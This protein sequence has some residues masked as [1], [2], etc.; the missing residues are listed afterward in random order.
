MK[1]E[2]KISNPSMYNYTRF[3][4]ELMHNLYVSGAPCSTEQPATQSVGTT[5]D[6]TKLACA[7]MTLTTGISS[8][9]SHTHILL[10]GGWIVY[11]NVLYIYFM[12]MVV[13][14]YVANKD[15]LTLYGALYYIFIVLAIMEGTVGMITINSIAWSTTIEYYFVPSTSTYLTYWQKKFS[16]AF[17][18]SKFLSLWNSFVWVRHHH[19]RFTSRNIAFLS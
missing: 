18:S 7:S 9:T 8:Y 4:G 16:N 17:L 11:C 2:Y 6:I 13:C 5:L 12:Y 15:N 14:I 3:N 1:R 10:I 19:P